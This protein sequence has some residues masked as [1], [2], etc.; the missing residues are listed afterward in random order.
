MLLAILSFEH[1]DSSDAHTRASL[2]DSQVTTPSRRLLRIL[3]PHSS[4]ATKLQVNT[5]HHHAVYT[6]RSP[7]WPCR[8][9]FGGVRQLVAAPGPW[10]TY[11]PSAKSC[12]ASS[13]ASLFFSSAS[14]NPGSLRGTAESMSCPSFSPCLTHTLIMSLSQVV[15]LHLPTL[16]LLVPGLCDRCKLGV[17]C[18]EPT[19]CCRDLNLPRHATPLLLSPSQWHPSG[20]W[21]PLPP[22]FR[23]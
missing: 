14:P 6:A 1:N 22:R 4:P 5:P 13:L 21:L 2:C 12:T 19:Q 8:S 20:T 10:L 11:I 9:P 23:L 3:P 18:P 16:F 7:R 17:V 15:H